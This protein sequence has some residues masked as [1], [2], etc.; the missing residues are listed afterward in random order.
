[1]RFNEILENEIFINTLAELNALEKNRKFCKHGIE[2]LFDVARTAYI[3]NLENSLGIDKDLIYAAAL[4]HDLGRVQEYKNSV[5]H[6]LASVEIARK[7]LAQT[8]YTPQETLEIVEAISNH[9]KTDEGDN[10]TTIIY[11]GDKLT[12]NCGMCN[13]LAEC[14]WSESKKNYKMRY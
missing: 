4:L 9:R 11:K 1:M 2:H 7:I 13:A 3:I 12:R 14:N 8:S 10:L 6:E 5:P